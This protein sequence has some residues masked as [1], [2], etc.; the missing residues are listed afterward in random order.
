MSLERKL[1]FTDIY[2]SMD[3]KIIVKFFSQNLVS[4]KRTT[5]SVKEI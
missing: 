2:S 1:S 5:L 3:K 4:R